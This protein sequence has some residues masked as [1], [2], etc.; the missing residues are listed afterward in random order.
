[1]RLRWTP[2]ATAAEERTIQVQLVELAEQ[3]Q[4][5]RTLRP[6]RV[7]VSRAR[8][9]EQFA[10]P[11]NSQLRMLWIDPSAAVFNR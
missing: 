3:A 6:W 4:V 9:A 2:S 10:L 8:H 1:M 7:V 5:L 11:L